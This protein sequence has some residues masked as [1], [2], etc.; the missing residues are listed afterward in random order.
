MLPFTLKPGYGL[1]SESQKTE[2]LPKRFACLNS[3]FKVYSNLKLVEF[4]L[5]WDIID[6]EILRSFC[7]SQ[8]L[9]YALKSGKANI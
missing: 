5:G 7:C 9:S 8:I 1:L 6:S 4:E 2:V 3:Q